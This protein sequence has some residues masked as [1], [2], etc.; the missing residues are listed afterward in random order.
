MDMTGLEY[1]NAYNFAVNLDELQNVL[2]SEISTV[3]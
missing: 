2:K 1:D 3:Q